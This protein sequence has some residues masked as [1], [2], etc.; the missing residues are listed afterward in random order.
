MVAATVKHMK[1][2]IFF[3]F[4]KGWSGIHGSASPCMAV[5][6]STTRIFQHKIIYILK[7]REELSLCCAKPSRW[8]SRK[9]V[10][11]I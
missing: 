11:L 2:L 5:L 9:H 1:V 3:F 6:L 8:L 10:A 4:V 7:P